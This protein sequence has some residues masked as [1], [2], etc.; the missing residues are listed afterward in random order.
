MWTATGRKS[1]GSLGFKDDLKQ[2]M[3]HLMNAAVVWVFIFQY[4]RLYWM[5]QLHGTLFPEG[6]LEEPLFPA[7][8]PGWIAC[9]QA[10]WVPR[11]FRYWVKVWMSGC[12]PPF[13]NLCHLLKS[14]PNPQNQQS[15]LFSSWILANTTTNPHY[16]VLIGHTHTGSD[17]HI[18]T[19]TWTHRHMHTWT[20]THSNANTHS[21]IYI[22]T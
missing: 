17:T 14:L 2:V 20:D 8:N 4:S 6:D 5:I 7:H 1:T 16:W 3:W 9:S 19:Y 15:R 13:P 12:P 11:F 18:C 22:C 21:H 10:V